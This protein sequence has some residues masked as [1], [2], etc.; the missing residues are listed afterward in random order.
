MMGHASIQIT[1]DIYGHIEFAAQQEAAKRL[2]ALLMA[3]K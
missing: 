3:G 1:K 2:A